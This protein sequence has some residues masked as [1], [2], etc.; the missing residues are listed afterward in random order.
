MPAAEALARLSDRFGDVVWPLLFGELQSAAEGYLSD[1]K[2]TWMDEMQDDQ[3]SDGIFEDEFTWRD[4]GAHKLLVATGHWCRKDDLSR[5]LT[6]VKPLL[7][8]TI[9]SHTCII[10]ANKH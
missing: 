10:G 6:Q 1:A 9:L 7:S 3:T 4:P 2:P 5:K 8:S